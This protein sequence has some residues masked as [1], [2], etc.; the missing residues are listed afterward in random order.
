MNQK[1]ED[2][3]GGGCVGVTTNYFVFIIICSGQNNRA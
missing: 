2:L 3:A 1:A